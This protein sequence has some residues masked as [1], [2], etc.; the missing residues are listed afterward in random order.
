MTCKTGRLGAFVLTVLLC[1]TAGGS[2]VERQT[3][4]GRVRGRVVRRLGRSVEEYRGIPYAEPPVGKLRFRPPQPKK[5]WE[6]TLDATSGSTGC[7]QVGVQ[8]C[9]F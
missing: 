8:T 7:P 3:T 5:A 6:G 2:H 9:V 4:E 1:A